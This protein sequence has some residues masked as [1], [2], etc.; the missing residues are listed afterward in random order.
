MLRKVKKTTSKKSSSWLFA[1]L[2]WVEH[3]NI[4]EQVNLEESFQGLQIFANMEWLKLKIGKKT[5]GGEE[6]AW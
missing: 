4:W 6:A 5:H 3:I 1:F 2:F